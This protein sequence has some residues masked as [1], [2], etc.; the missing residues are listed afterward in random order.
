MSGLPRELLKWLQSL[1][2]TYSVKNIKR[3]FSNGF[4]VAEICSRYYVADVEMHSYDNGQSLQRKLDNW[5]QLNKFFKKLRGRTGFEL[6]KTLID[7]VV[8]CK[9][10]ESPTLLIAAIYR[11]LTGREVRLNAA[12]TDPGLGEDPAYTRPN[13]TSLLAS[14]MKESELATTLSDNNTA[15]AR[16]KSLLDDH[17]D[18][19]RADREN[20]PSRYGVPGS[21][22]SQTQSAMLSGMLRAS[23]PK[24][25]QQTVEATQVRFQEVKVTAVDRNIASIRASRDQMV[26][27]SSYASGGGVEPVMPPIGGGPGMDSAMPPPPPDGGEGRVVIADVLTRLALG[28]CP[29]AM[30][31]LGAMVDVP[32]FRVALSQMEEL[33]KSVMLDVMKAATSEAA[34]GIAAACKA[35][36]ANAYELY[37]LFAPALSRAEDLDVY[38]AICSFL[39]AVGEG[40]SSLT[41][42]A[43]TVLTEYALPFIVPHLKRLRSPAKLSYLLAVVYAMV[44][45]LSTTPLHAPTLP[46]SSFSDS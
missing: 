17:T 22:A 43:Y 34:V 14:Q 26:K 4:L 11:E 42:A 30:S 21:N 15:A 5:A 41:T 1:D 35:S 13:A 39:C 19:L 40:L 9:N 8:H 29:E 46:L 23:A 37:A 24:P 25:V 44:R 20:Q 6:D 33:P 28:A 31:Y 12:A 16:A 10:V 3:D 38:A 36:P 45:L 32:D 7:D 27:S 2:L 18:Q